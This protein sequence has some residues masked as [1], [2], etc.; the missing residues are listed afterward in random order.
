MLKYVKKY[1]LLA[2]LAAA[3]MV[4]EVSMD[5]I[6]PTLMSRIVDEGV[7]GAGSGAGSMENLSPS[8]ASSSLT[9]RPPTSIRARRRRSRA[10]CTVS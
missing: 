1:T 4:G 9:R 2:L 8:R 7:L 10:P 5:L 6:Q 3:F